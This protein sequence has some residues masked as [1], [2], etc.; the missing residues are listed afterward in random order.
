M[1]VIGSISYNTLKRIGVGQGMNS[2]VYLADEPQLGGRVAVKE[3]DKSLFRNPADY[4]NEAR[5][6]FAAT[7][8]NVIAVQ[9]ACETPTTI[10]LVMPYYQKGSLFDRIQNCPLQLSE[11]LRVAQGV[12][13]GLAHI[14]LAHYVHFDIKPSNVLFSDADKP[15]VADF[16]QS[17]AIDPTTGIVTV[18]PLYFNAQP[19]ETISTGVA[20][21]VA[22]IYHVG[23]LLYRALNGDKFFTS[24]IPGDDAV[25]MKKISKGKFPDR[26]LFMPHVPA[27]IRTL[28]RK[29]LRVKPAERFQAAMEMADAFSRVSLA[30]DWAMEPLSLD[31]FRWRASRTSCAD[32]I[33]EMINQGSMWGVEAF[34]EKPGGPRR[35][36]GKNENWRSGLT[37]DEAHA[38]LT[39]VFDRLQ[40]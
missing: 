8:E 29:A 6:M 22:D 38:H 40:E 16:G 11:A 17:R 25:L 5:T 2:K 7:H 26:S 20:T 15:M 24:Q 28:V 30:L 1:Q 13:A 23:L 14:H 12:L 35:A 4:F 39:D 27:R 9:Y 3:I 18:P 19:P 36:K 31:G 21:T 33:V 32:F 34:T 37:L 10:S